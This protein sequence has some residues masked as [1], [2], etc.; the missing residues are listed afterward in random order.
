M[1]WF[2][3]ELNVP[4]IKFPL[5]LSEIRTWH[6][7]CEDMDLIPGF[8]QWVKDPM[9][10]QTRVADVAQIW[11]CCGC[12]CGIGLIAALIR[13]L[14]WELPYAA[15]T[16]IKRKRMCPQE[17]CMWAA[18]AACR[19]ECSV[20]SSREKM[21]KWENCMSMFSSFLFFLNIVP[22]TCIHYSTIC[23]YWVRTMCQGALYALWRCK[24]TSL[25]ELTL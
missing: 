5:W 13:L 18:R 25:Q 22:G 23:I 24:R 14:A 15:G 4:T 10:P 7:L 16:A 6:R 19:I 11:C 12:G 2:A 8:P 9:L 1:N 3:W 17:G 21:G 20:G